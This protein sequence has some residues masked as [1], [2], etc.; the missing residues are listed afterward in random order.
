MLVNSIRQEGDLF[1]LLS[2]PIVG[3]VGISGYS[4]SLLGS[5]GTWLSKEFRYSRDGVNFSSYIALSSPNIT[6]LVFTAGEFVVFEFQYVRSVGSDRTVVSITLTETS[7]TLPWEHTYFDQ[8]NYKQ[9]F[10]QNDQEL[11]NW[12][13]NVLNKVY[14]KDGGVIPSYIERKNDAE[15]DKDFIEF[16]TSICLVFGLDVKLARVVSRFYEN[17]PFIRPYLESRGLFVSRRNNN[18]TMQY[19]METYYHQMA[20]RGTKHITDSVINGGD[21]VDG[22]LVRLLS[23]VEH[24]ELV[25]CPHKKEHF[26][27]NLR[28]SSPLYRGLKK[29]QNANKIT[30]TGQRVRIDSSLDYIFSF[31]VQTASIVELEFIVEDRYGNP[32]QCK[33]RDTGVSTN[34]ALSGITLQRSDKTFNIE[35]LLY[36][37]T[38]AV[39]AT[40]TTNIKQGHN[41]IFPQDIGYI[42][43]V[44]SL[45]GVI[46]VVTNNVF[47][48]VVKTPYSHGLVQVPN[49]ITAFLKNQSKYTFEEVKQHV[50]RFL[51]PY[52]STIYFIAINSVYLDPDNPLNSYVDD[53]YVDD[54]YI[55]PQT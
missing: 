34:T 55:I 47:L 1:T 21:E 31:S 16:W 2:K 28:N 9:Y 54:D 42:T 4:E 43:P 10:N 14:R 15:S 35:V 52:S 7:T 27:W 26:G 29:N 22:E 24:D 8:S 36:N 46:T 38:T 3:I 48:G 23:N 41:L 45:S 30:Q 12:A 50:R 37:W 51:I 53:D 39:D 32:I 25:F 18:A 11:L 40:D 6:S 20:N 33:R 13:I 5:T 49:F 44:V 19:L 17:D